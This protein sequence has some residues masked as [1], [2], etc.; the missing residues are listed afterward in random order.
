MHPAVT[1]KISIAGLS[2]QS[3][4]TS[5]DIPAYANMPIKMYSSRFSILLLSPFEYKYIIHTLYMIVNKKCDLFI[6]KTQINSGGGTRNHL[7]SLELTPKNANFRKFLL[8]PAKMCDI[9]RIS[10]IID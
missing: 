5:T 8:T 7:A 1:Q 9:I 4:E 6:T 2:A 3:I 10:T